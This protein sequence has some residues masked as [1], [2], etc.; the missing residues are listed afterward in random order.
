MQ[1]E[2]A[3]GRI[4]R[5][6]H[7][8]IGHQALKLVNVDMNKVVDVHRKQEGGQYGKGVKQDIKDPYGRIG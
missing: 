2:Q 1:A 6:Q 5:H 7:V 4:Y 8:K 3:Y